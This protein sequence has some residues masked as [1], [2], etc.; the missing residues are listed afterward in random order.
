M[1]YRFASPVISIRIE[2]ETRFVGEG[3]IEDQRE[4]DKGNDSR[5]H[6]PRRRSL[7]VTRKL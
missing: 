2:N 3:A 1:T 4:G 7:M 6:E 5:P